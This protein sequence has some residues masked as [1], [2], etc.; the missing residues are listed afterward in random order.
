MR[1]IDKLQD[2]FPEQEILQADGFDNAIIGLEP[3]SGKVIY[4]IQKMTMVLIDEGLTH[5]DAI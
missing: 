3:L 5:E 2:M 1:N 4:D